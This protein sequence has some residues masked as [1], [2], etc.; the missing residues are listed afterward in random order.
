MFR[1][2]SLGSGGSGIHAPTGTSTTN[3]ASMQNAN[4]VFSTQMAEQQQAQFSRCFK[5]TGN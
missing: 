2:Q 5:G 1:L 4:G 3:S